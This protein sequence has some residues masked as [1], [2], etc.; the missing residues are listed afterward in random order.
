M[1]GGLMKTESQA[2]HHT[3]GLSSEFEVCLVFMN[4]SPRNHI[5]SQIIRTLKS[6]LI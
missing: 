3:I 5:I 4:Q 2:M 1:I 6:T